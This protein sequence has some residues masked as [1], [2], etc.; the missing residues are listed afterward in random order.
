VALDSTGLCF[1]RLVVPETQRAVRRT[2]ELVGMAEFVP[3]HDSLEEALIEA[4]ED[5]AVEE[6]APEVTS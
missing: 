3:V 5:D 1:V 6:S 4:R 2:F